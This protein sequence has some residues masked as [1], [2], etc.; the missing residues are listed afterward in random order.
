MH[1]AGDSIMC[2]GDINRH[3]GRRI[4]GFDWV[5]GGHGVSHRNL[6]GRMFFDF[7]LEKKLCV[8]NTWLRRE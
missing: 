1:C 8:S 7:Y 5:H 6:E 4:G 2:L 3:T